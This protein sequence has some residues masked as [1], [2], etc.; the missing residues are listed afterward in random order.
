MHCH[1]VGRATNSRLGVTGCVTTNDAWR[2]SQYSSRLQLDDA[3]HR[4]IMAPAV[5]IARRAPRSKPRNPVARSPLLGKGGVHE[6]S[7][8]AKRRRARML[9]QKQVR[10]KDGDA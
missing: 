3:F 2:R 7:T 1:G 4:D 9:L 5:K 8:A 10:T 6:K